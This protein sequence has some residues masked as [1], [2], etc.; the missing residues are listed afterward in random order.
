MY[1]H[2][3][4]LH[5]RLQ[6]SYY[7]DIGYTK[8]GIF[9][10]CRYLSRRARSLPSEMIRQRAKSYLS[11]S[12]YSVS[13]DVYHNKHGYIGKKFGKKS[14]SQAMS[15]DCSL[16]YTV[17][18]DSILYIS[19]SQYMFYIPKTFTIIKRSL[20]DYGT[21]LNCGIFFCFS[22]SHNLPS[23]PACFIKFTV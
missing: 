16:F 22:V 2:V 11:T 15:V 6:E 10:C 4:I 9:T 14:Y 19:H 12:I 17:K 3:Y 23:F 7:L 20:F 18:F 1:S 5:Q 21:S 8:T 13:H